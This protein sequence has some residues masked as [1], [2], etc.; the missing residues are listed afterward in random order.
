VH[1]ICNTRAPLGERLFVDAD[2]QHICMKIRSLLIGTAFPVRVS[3][4][5]PRRPLFVSAG[6][7]MAPGRRRPLSLCDRIVAIVKGFR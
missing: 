1:A 3:S 7:L 6:I 2:N 4:A 5:S